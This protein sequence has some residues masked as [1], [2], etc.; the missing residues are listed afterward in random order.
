LRGVDTN[1][2]VRYLTQDEPSQAQS[3]DTLM[4]AVRASDERLHIDDVVLC[5]L[6]WV[7]RGAYRLDVETIAAALG[8]I[9]DT[10]LFAFE[11]RDLLRQTLD[12]YR[13]G[14]ADFADYLI[15]RRNVRAG[16]LSTLTFDGALAGS[17]AFAML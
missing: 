9:L 6:V 3:V 4:E 14:P 17:T 1:V 2:L 5:E 8:K 12:D 16:C 7:L 11:D 15:G 10:G 13:R